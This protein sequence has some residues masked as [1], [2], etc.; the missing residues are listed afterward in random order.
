MMMSKLKVVA[1]QAS[2]FALVLL[3]GST[4]FGQGTSLSVNV[5]ADAGVCVGGVSPV[6]VNYTVTSTGS[7]DGATVGYSVNAGTVVG[8]PGIAG[9]LTSDGGGWTKGNGS[10][11][12]ATGQ[13]ILNLANGDYDIEVCAEQNGAEKKTD[14]STVHVQ[15]ACNQE[16]KCDQA[17]TR[18]GEV[19]GNKNL[20]KSDARINVQLKGLFGA[21]ALLE[22]KDGNG[23]TVQTLSTSRNGDSCVY[24][25]NLDPK[26]WSG[27]QPP[28]PGLYTFTVTGDNL[29]TYAFSADLICSTPKK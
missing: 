23:G 16:D 6:T 17:A 22:V 13:F 1:A 11:K 25:W 4:A 3:S 8:L 19:V 2:V 12:T 7:A 27:A 9:G 21:N 18:F 24:H 20:C 15:V 26:T 29:A 14:C 5:S 28:A 10:N